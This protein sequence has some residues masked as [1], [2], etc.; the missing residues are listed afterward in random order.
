MIDDYSSVC[1]RLEQCKP[2]FNKKYGVGSSLALLKLDN[3]FPS[4][5][6]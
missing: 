2:Y 1:L 6:S 3:R 4:L 5:V